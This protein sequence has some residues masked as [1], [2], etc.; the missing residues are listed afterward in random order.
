MTPAEHATAV[1]AFI[2]RS[3]DPQLI[4]PSD[5]EITAATVHAHLSVA[6]GTGDAYTTADTL[7]AEAEA[8]PSFARRDRLAVAV[9]HAIRA[10]R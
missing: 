6:L 7:L 1:A 3:G 10:D 2:T 4:S 9:L 5:L 8:L